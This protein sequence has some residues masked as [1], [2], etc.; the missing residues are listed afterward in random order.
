MG[1][2]VGGMQNVKIFVLYLMENVGTPLDF[3]TLNDIVMQ[4]DFV[5]YLDFAEAFH[6]MLDDGLIS[7]A[8]LEGTDVLYAITEKGRTVAESLHSDILSSLL[9][10]SLTAA[11][12][13]LDFKRRGIE[14]RCNHTRREDGRY[15]VYCALVERGTVIFETTLVVDSADRAKRMAENFR[16]RPEVIYRGAH[17]LL[18]GNMNFLLD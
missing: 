11:L 13:Y 7:E 2:A 17:A 6:K 1:S 16:D 4:T 15:D 8:G 12:R 5:M 18:A 9:D 10:K 14:V 3:V